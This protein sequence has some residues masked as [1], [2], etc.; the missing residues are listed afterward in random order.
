[1]KSYCLSSQGFLRQQ[2]RAHALCLRHIHFHVVSIILSL[3]KTRSNPKAI[4]AFIIRF[5]ICISCF[6]LCTVGATRPNNTGQSR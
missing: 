2:L 5:H 3:C 1:M 6:L 4:G